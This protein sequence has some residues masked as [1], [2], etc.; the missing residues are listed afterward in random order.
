M[1]G[2]PVPGRRVAR[3]LPPGA[4]DAA[5]LVEARP[6]L[7]LSWRGR[8]TIH[9]CL[10]LHE[11]RLLLDLEAQWFQARAGRHVRRRSDRTRR[12]CIA[13]PRSG[14]RSRGNTRR[15][16]LAKTRSIGPNARRLR[17]SQGR[18]ISRLTLISRRCSGSLPG[19]TTTAVRSRKPFLV[20]SAVGRPSPVGRIGIHLRR[21]LLEDRRGG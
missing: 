12:P 20:T 5:R 2:V 18:K 14:R 7:G 17:C 3:L 16:P 10:P 13:H 11:S 6:R 19:Q 9:A 21:S 15:G 1:A 8:T 4:R